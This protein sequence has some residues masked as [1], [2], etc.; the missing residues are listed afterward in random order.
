MRYVQDQD[1]YGSSSLYD[2][3]SSLEE[4]KMELEDTKADYQY[5]SGHIETNHNIDSVFLPVTD[6]IADAGINQLLQELV[7]L[8]NELNT[9]RQNIQDDHPYYQS[10]EQQYQELKKTLLTKVNLFIDHLDKSMAKL[11]KKMAEIKLKIPT[12]PFK[13]RH[14][15]E[16][17]RKIKQNEDV[18]DILSEKK[19][20]FELIKASK[21]PNYYL[22]KE[23]R[24]AEATQTFPNPLLN[25]SLA[26]LLGFILPSMITIYQKNLSP[27]IE[28]KEEIVNNSSIPILHA[29]ETNPFKTQLPVYYH[30]QSAITDGFRHVRAKILYRIKSEQQRV[31]MVTSMVSGEG[32]SFLS[33]NLA[34]SFAMSGKK[35]LI[36]NADIRKPSLDKI[37]SVKEKKGLSDYFANKSGYKELIQ[38][39]PMENLYI[40]PH[41]KSSSNTGDLFSE[42]KIKALLDH[43]SNEFDFILFDSPPFSIV[44]ESTLIAE[45]CHCNIFV[46]R[47]D[48]SPKKI[49]DSLEEI[50][51]EGRVKNMLL[52]VNGVKKL[53]RFGFEYYH[54]YDYSYGFGHYKDY[55]NASNH[56]NKHLAQHKKVVQY[57]NKKSSK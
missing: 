7:T 28:D 3:L 13:E 50:K 35:T 34:I 27:K 42:D 45:Q 38:P 23:P 21:A 47:H 20:E 8:Q 25:Y 5:L 55:Y 32:K 57:T 24:L 44:P 15:R 9:S 48:Y 52:M 39:L 41:G 36:I 31:I 56:R 49:L 22:L 16:L 17:L 46:I 43:L 30:P 33:A 6:N 26:F 40:L 4:Q 51:N 1:Q 10:V 37:F 14:Y 18:L 53:K 11:D 19:I 29:L 2:R 54:G 12:V